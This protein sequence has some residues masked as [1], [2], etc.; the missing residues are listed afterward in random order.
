MTCNETLYHCTLNSFP[1]TGNFT[2]SGSRVINCCGN[3]NQLG[4]SV[5][6]GLLLLVY[7]LYL[8]GRSRFALFLNSF[9]VFLVW[10]LFGVSPVCLLTDDFTTYN[11]V[12]SLHYWDVVFA[13]LWLFPVIWTICRFIFSFR[14]RLSLAFSYTWCALCTRFPFVLDTSSTLARYH[15]L[16]VEIRSDGTFNLVVDHAGTSSTVASTLVKLEPTIICGPNT[17]KTVKKVKTEGE[18]Q[19]YKMGGDHIQA[20]QL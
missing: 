8:F 10:L 20:L 4:S 7:L 15:P 17:T 11:P 13:C 16:P 6:L 3:Y 18:I 19:T 9:L 5:S 12:S 1:A 2:T 14:R